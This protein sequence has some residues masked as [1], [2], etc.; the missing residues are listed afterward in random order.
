MKLAKISIP[1]KAA[2]K[3]FTV[4]IF[5]LF[6]FS[7]TIGN[8]SPFAI[9]GILTLAL[10]I[11]LLMLGYEYLYWKNFEYSIESDGLKLI[12]GVI[13]KN[14]RDIPLKRIQNVDVSRNIVQRILGIAQ[15]NVETAG[16]GK[17]EATL[18]YL[19]HSDAEQMQQR[20]RELK[21]R[22]NA[23]RSDE[24][25][26]SGKQREDFVLSDKNLGILS[27]ASAVD[28]RIIGGIGFLMSIIGSAGISYVEGALPQTLGIIVIILLGLIGFLSIWASSAVSIFVKYYDFKLYFHENALEYERGLLNRASGTI[29]EEKIQDVIIEEN[30]IQRYFGFASLKVETAGYSG[31]KDQGQIDTGAETVIPLAKRAE[32]ENFAEEIGGYS[33]PELLSINE[34]ARKRYFRRYVLTGTILATVIFGVSQLYSVPWPAY[35]PSAILIMSS[36]KAAQLKWESIGY[37]LGKKRVFTR[38][39][40]WNRKTYVVPYFRLQNLMRTQ[41][42]FQ[43]RWS[44]STLV[45]DTAG[46]V[47]SY[48]NIPDMSEEKAE[49]IKIR[50][51]HKFQESLKR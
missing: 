23:D 16:G 39:G 26:D 19:D 43:K 31:A 51:F 10:V 37:S 34:R 18:K 13:S 15:V 22:R 12:S 42:I 21:N 48:P 45:L 5:S 28:Y 33:K 35:V 9:I 47:L 11:L 8:R 14:D 2:K 38:K 50:L 41:T 25:E 3:L 17:T 40:F 1:Y 49:E 29:P 4:A 24:K 36:K 30:F 46:S 32:V 7:G 44:Q 20:V 6:A 27:V